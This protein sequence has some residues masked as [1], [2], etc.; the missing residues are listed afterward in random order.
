VAN[1]DQEDVVAEHAQYDVVIVGASIAGCA[2]A[3]LYGRR[4]LRVAL[5]ERHANPATFKRVCTHFIQPSATPTIQ[6]LGLD[7]TIEAAGGLRNGVEAWTRWGWIRPPTVDIGG[8][9]PVPAYGYN[10]RREKLDPMVRTMAA[11]TP[12]V[13]LMFGLSVDR[14]LLSGGRFCGVRAVTTDRRPIQITGTLVVG[15]DGRS[16]RVAELADVKTA[17]KPNN[18]FAYW[19]Y[20]KD[21]PLSS[22]SNSQVWIREPDF[23]YTFP[24]D[25]HL[26]IAL[27]APTKDKLPAWRTDL[28]ASFLRAFDGLPGAPSLREAEQV[29]DLLGMVDLTNIS[30]ETT[31]PGLALIGDAAIASDP[32]WGVGCGW[33]FQSAEWLVAST[34]AAVGNNADVDG[35]LERY[36]KRHHA[37]LAGHHFIISDFSSGRPLNPIEKLFMSAA[38]RDAKV[39]AHFG[40]FGA[41]QIGVRAFLSPKAIAYASWVNLSA[42]RRKPAQAA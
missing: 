9:P 36:R 35:A 15:A 2:A 39:A 6:R 24:N 40:A 8:S 38:T 3:T 19:A 27:Y 21:L 28:H 41:R 23:A 26:T 25:D 37:A 33:A 4:G 1:P 31:R 20:Y 32:I 18:R 22:G 5:I 11:D 7:R 30:R 42:G 17:V 14:L 16:S 12:G 13:D 10:I 29:G 34:A